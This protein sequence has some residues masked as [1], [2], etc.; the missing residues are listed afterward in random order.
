M[1]DQ[2]VLKSYLS[3]LSNE[4]EDVNID[5]SFNG[6]VEKLI[7][8]VIG[9]LFPNLKT[10][11]LDTP[12]TI[13]KLMIPPHKTIVSLSITNQHLEF[14]MP[15]L[16]PLLETLNLSNNMLKE[17][18]FNSPQQCYPNLKVAIFDDNPLLKNIDTISKSV[19]ELSIL[20]TS[21]PTPGPISTLWKL[22]NVI[23]QNST[24]VLG[25]KPKGSEITKLVEHVNATL[26]S[27]KGNPA[28]I[29]QMA[30]SSMNKLIDYKSLNMLNKT[31]T[32]IVNEL[33]KIYIKNTNELPQ[34]P[35]SPSEPPPKPLTPPKNAQ[36]IF[37]PYNETEINDQTS[38]QIFDELLE[39]MPK[40][41][42]TININRVLHGRIHINLEI[43][44]LT[45]VQ[46]IAFTTPGSITS[47]SFHNPPLKLRVFEAVS[48]SIDEWKVVGMPYLEELNLSNNRIKNLD[49][50]DYHHL[51]IANLNNNRLEYFSR[52][53]SYL[54]EIQVNGKREFVATKSSAGP[55]NL[56]NTLIKLSIN[57]NRISYL[58]LV[59]APS[60]VSLYAMNNPNIKIVN[61]PTSLRDLRIDASVSD[62]PVSEKAK[63]AADA[64]DYEQ[65]LNMYYT[66]KSKY[67]ESRMSMLERA[68][69]SKNT[70]KERMTALESVRPLC[71]QCQ[72]PV[73]TQFVQKK[74]RKL[75]ARCGDTSHPCELNITI[76]TGFYTKIDT[77]L[78]NAAA[79]LEHSRELIIRHK[80]D[81]I[82]KFM[83]ETESV[84]KFKLLLE[85]YDY[86]KYY[87]NHYLT[88]Y[89]ETYFSEIR[90][91][92]ITEKL[93]RVYDIS[94]EIKQ[95]IDSGSDEHTAMQKYI[96]EYLI[97]LQNLRELK[98]EIMEIFETN[99]SV[100]DN[101]FIANLFQNE[102]NLDR[103]THIFDN[104][105]KVISFVYGGAAKP[106][107]T[108]NNSVSNTSDIFK[109]EELNTSDI[110]KDE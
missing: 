81:T 76:F 88:L 2:V 109:D 30:G 68:Y 43:H 17:V 106:T 32:E 65:S 39:T 28:A 21:V 89:N 8:P 49:L 99:A 70:K 36:N 67:E 58:D 102:V 3:G 74:N 19:K 83:P 25:D 33:H 72:R 45:N 94:T 46:K 48:Q 16:M 40:S 22:N 60:L 10:L 37:P 38:Q 55:A 20:N 66:L 57:N 59:N 104:Q 41:I 51:K 92:A 75:Y 62:T 47:V 9:N 108:L 82:F 96:D 103:L 27:H 71:I 23:Q 87:Y 110:F 101:Y 91:Q 26:K 100:K 77:E 95:L 97:E 31:D 1:N 5:T 44:G 73:G 7:F 52:E 54:K 42:T 85:N 84:E 90:K 29:V 15:S 50:S 18:I 14:F 69:N 80:M 61:R 6:D 12:G 56:P 24:H 11:S 35:Q 86:V 105:P 34:E 78:A 13:H 53:E 107:K 93:Q 4:E 79:D 64:F 98:Y 63:H